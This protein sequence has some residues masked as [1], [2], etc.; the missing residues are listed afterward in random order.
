MLSNGV[1]LSEGSSCRQ[2]LSSCS[3]SQTAGLS[4][5]HVVDGESATGL[6]GAAMIMVSSV[7]LGLHKSR[8]VVAV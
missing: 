7:L 5:K 8:C 6:A 2:V 3:Y 1:S 4:V